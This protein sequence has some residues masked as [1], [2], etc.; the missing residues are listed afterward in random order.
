[1][2]GIMDRYQLDI[3]SAGK[4]YN[5]VRRAICSGFFKNAAKKDPT[6]GYKTMVDNQVVYIHPSSALFN[7]QPQW[8]IYHELVLTTK[9]YMRECTAIEP[10][11]LIELAPAFFKVADPTY[12]SKRK[13]ME[14]IEPMYNKYEEPN[15]WRISKQRR[16]K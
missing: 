2:L 9:E 7:H 3:V 5:K 10:K 12:L 4:N 14:R 6:E 16:K 11:W 15:S 13:R 1:M 8:V